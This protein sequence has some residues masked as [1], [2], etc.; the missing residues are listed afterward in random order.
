MQFAANSRYLDDFERSGCVGYAN[1]YSGWD[2]LDNR[3]GR[4]EQGVSG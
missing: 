4:G 3:S 1:Y 2:D